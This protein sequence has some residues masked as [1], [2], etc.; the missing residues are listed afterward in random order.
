M[1]RMVV[2]QKIK[3]I[4]KKE[5]K[6]RKE[7]NTELPYDPA[8]ALLGMYPQKLKAGTRTDIS[9]S[10]EPNGESNTRAVDG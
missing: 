9:C 4:K 8:T 7:T 5:K 1:N 6:E 2:P 3:K 10:Q